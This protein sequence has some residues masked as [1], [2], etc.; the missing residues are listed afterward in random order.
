LQVFDIY[1]ET[2]QQRGRTFPFGLH[3]TPYSTPALPDIFKK[4]KE[5]AANKITLTHASN[6]I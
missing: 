4:M 6:I 2:Y 1:I 5:K 3:A